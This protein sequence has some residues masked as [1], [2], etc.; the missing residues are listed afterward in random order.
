[1]AIKSTQT[2]LEEVQAAIEQALASQ[3]MGSGGD[4][5]RRADLKVLYDREDQLLKRLRAETGTSTPAINTGLI[6]GQ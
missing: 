1:M 6:R 4:R 2:Q 3:E 5:V